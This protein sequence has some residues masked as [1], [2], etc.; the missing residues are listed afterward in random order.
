MEITDINQLDFDK[1][2]TY[3][4]YLL[5]KFKERVELVKG[6]IL[7]MS[8]APSRKHQEVAG[9]FYYAMRKNFHSD[10]C[11]LFFAP[12]DVRI[13]RRNDHNEEIFTVVQPDLCVIC[14]ENKLDERGAIGA[15]DLIIEILSP[16]N[17]RKELKT[18]FDLY[19]ESGVLEYW[20][21]NPSEETVLVNVLEN[22]TY[23]TLRPVVDDLIISP[24][25]PELK[26]ISTEV[27]KGKNEP[28]RHEDNHEEH[29]D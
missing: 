28:Q 14:D 22:G 24:T 29:W 5:W 18:K 23:R 25:F 7:K 11:Q 17:S 26:I 3:A 10:R 27:F 16:G 20:V 6:K 4:D 19:E 1:T 8:P 21:V 15:P 9:N 2:Y 12:F 13:P